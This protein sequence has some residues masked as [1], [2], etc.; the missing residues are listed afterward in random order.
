MKW[1]PILIC[2]PMIFGFSADKPAYKLFESRGKQIKYEKMLKQLAEADVVL[3]GEYHNNSILHWLELQIV[4][5]LTKAKQGNLVMGSEV[6]ETD[7][8]LILDEYL[9]DLISL[10][11]LEQEA[12][13]WNNFQT[14]YLPLLEWAKS[15]DLPFIATNIPRRY[16]SMVARGGFESLEKLDEQAKA[17]LPPLPIEVDFE[18]SSYKAML[19]G[20]GGHGHGGGMSAENMVRA[21]AIKDATMANAI[22]QNLKPGQTFYHVNGAYH[23]DYHQGIAWYLKQLKPELKILTLSAHETEPSWDIEKAAFEKADYLIAVPSDMI[24]TY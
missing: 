14:D 12:K 24:K 7:D 16:A 2:I 13:T 1:L 9:G 3:F 19:E 15:Q 8:Q 11:S 18:L 6:F 21:Q 20:M 23:S 5:D 4:K 17:F 10:R 22:I